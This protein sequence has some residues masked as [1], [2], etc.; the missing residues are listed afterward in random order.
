M[1]RVGVA[2]WPGTP[3]RETVKLGRLADLAGLDS[4]WITESTLAPGR[5]AISILGSL[6]AVTSKVKLATGIINIFTRTPTLIASTAATLDELSEGR[7][8]LG[9]GTGHRDPLRRWH[10]VEFNKPLTRM[11]EYVET[12]RLILGGGPVNYKGRT[13]IIDGFSL[14]V[15]PPR[16]TPVYVAAV[17]PQ[18]AKLAG[19]IADGVLITLN[20]L[21]ELKK[22]II[23]ATTTAKRNERVLDIAAFAISFISD[24]QEQNWKAARRV[25]AMYCSALFYNKVFANAGYEEEAREIARLWAENRREAAYGLVTEGMV[26]DFASLGVD[27]TVKTMET[28][29]DAG[30]TLPIA[31]VV[32]TDDF[33]RSCSRL[34]SQLV[35]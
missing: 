12:I 3:A 6:S 11:R 5:D 20:T 14:Q 15:K 13:V 33:E 17:G 35:G 10:S 32:Y 30:V 34:F 24:D 25:L 1:N 19:E 26:R 27:E 31:S 29:R 16:V 23:E 7:M 22:L 18:M 8:I 21:M 28:Y 4:V 2:L 9:L